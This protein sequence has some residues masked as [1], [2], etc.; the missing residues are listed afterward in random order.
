MLPRKLYVG[1]SIIKWK[2]SWIIVMVY[3]MYS[4]KFIESNY[5]QEV[6]FPFIS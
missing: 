4:K 2:T 5:C 3:R 6:Q 1:K